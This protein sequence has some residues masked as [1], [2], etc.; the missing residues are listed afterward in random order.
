[1]P[2]SEAR[3]STSGGPGAPSSTTWRRERLL[4]IGSSYAVPTVPNDQSAPPPDSG[5][6]AETTEESPLAG[7]PTEMSRSYGTLPVPRRKLFHIKSLKS[8]AARRGLPELPHITLPGRNALSNPGSPTYTPSILRETY[9]RLS[10]QRPISAYDAPLITKGEAD[11]DMGSKINGIRV[12][13]SSFSSIDWMH[14]AIKDSAR[15]SRLRRRKSVRARIRLA[16]DRS[17][18]W[19]I[20]TI[21]G[22]LTAIV[23]FL[24]VR[25]EQ[26]L[27]DL[28]EGYCGDDWSKAKRF[29]CPQPDETSVL[30]PKFFTEDACPAWRTWSSVFHFREG[31]TGEEAVEYVTYASVAV[32][33]RFYSSCSIVDQI[34]LVIP[35]IRFLC[36]Y[37]VS[38]QLYHL[39]N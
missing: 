24:V 37:S 21:V 22:F 32:R 34:P 11:T 20:V 23:A 29:C 27:F 15:Y 36:P 12:W 5:A 8:F 9:S 26:W 39:C 10:V 30:L 2:G 6:T 33:T 28:K 38:Y 1:M 13:Y 35:R 31:E 3:P 17:L 25:A 7:R 19:I 14:D 16:I 18:G 4:R